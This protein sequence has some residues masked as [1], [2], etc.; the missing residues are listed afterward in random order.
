LVFCGV[1]GGPCS[2]RGGGRWLVPPTWTTGPAPTGPRSVAR[3]W[4][5]RVLC[6]LR[7]G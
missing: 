7:T 1:C 3:N 2:I 6:G 4:R 5:D